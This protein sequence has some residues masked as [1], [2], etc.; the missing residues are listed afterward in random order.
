MTLK[1]CPF[2]RQERKRIDDRTTRQRGEKRREESTEVDTKEKEGGDGERKTGKGKGEMRGLMETP[3]VYKQSGD[4]GAEVSRDGYGGGQYQERVSEM[5]VECK[6]GMTKDRARQ[7]L[8]FM[9]KS[10][11]KGQVLD[12]I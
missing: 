8:K 1:N 4:T 6:G 11:D 5:F 7:F 10:L 9:A 2:T 3:P 12:N